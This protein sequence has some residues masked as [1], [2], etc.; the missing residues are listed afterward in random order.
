MIV[1]SLE[2]FDSGGRSPC[3]LH[4]G[5]DVTFANYSIHQTGAAR[6]RLISQATMR[7]NHSAFHRIWFR[8]RAFLRPR[9]L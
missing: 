5:F 8:P 2:D 3:A 7:K 9:G 6:K 1:S 4:D